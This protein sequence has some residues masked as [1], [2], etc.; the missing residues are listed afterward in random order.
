MSA[1]PWATMMT[2]ADLTPNGDL[3]RNR[4]RNRQLA[5]AGVFTWIFASAFEYPCTRC[6]AILGGHAGPRIS[7][8]TQL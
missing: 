2:S 7:R 3:Q 1:K 8:V 4:L 6:R 5:P